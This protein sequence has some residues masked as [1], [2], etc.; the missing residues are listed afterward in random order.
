MA[1][2]TVKKRANFM[3]DLKLKITQVGVSLQTSRQLIVFLVKSVV[4]VFVMKLE[5]GRGKREERARN[6]VT[7]HAVLC[8]DTCINQ[9][10][11]SNKLSCSFFFALTKILFLSS[12][13]A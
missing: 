3:T 2:L 10:C 5:V 4:V 1:A 11:F 6:D 9:H 13:K 8:C 12:S 7:R